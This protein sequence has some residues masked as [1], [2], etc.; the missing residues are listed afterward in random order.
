MPLR[1]L[2]KKNLSSLEKWKNGKEMHWAC[3]SGLEV[4]KLPMTKITNIEHR[5]LNIEDLKHLTS[6]LK[7]NVRCQMA[8]G[9][10]QKF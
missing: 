10:C 4:P 7:K 2:D 8:K 3:Q 6:D 5:I 9:K 1:P